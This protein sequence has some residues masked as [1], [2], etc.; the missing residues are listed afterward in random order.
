MNQAQS[1][2]TAPLTTKVKSPNVSTLIGSVRT[3][4]MGQMIALANP[5][6]TEA[7]SAI[8]N[9]RT[10]KPRTKFATTNNATAETNQ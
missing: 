2:R 5:I 10:L 4:S 6:R 3:M 9:E 1:L 7:R 8:L